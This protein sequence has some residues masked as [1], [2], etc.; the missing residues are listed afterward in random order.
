MSLPADAAEGTLR[1]LIQASPL[2]ITALDPDGVVLVWN[3]AAERVF[4]WTAD[5]IVG[6]SVPL[7][8]EGGEEEHRALRER[9]LAGEAIAGVEVRRRC[10]DGSIVDVRLSTAPL[11]DGAGNV[12]GAMAILED[13]TQQKHADE[14]LRQSE[15]RFRAIFDSARVGIVVTSPDGFVVESN[16][17]FRSMVGYSEQELAVMPF[18][19]YTHP[20][21]LVLNLG[22]FEELRAGARDSYEIVKRLIRKDGDLRW[23]RLTTSRASD[24][25]GR[26]V[27][28]AVIDDVTEKKR[29]EEALRASEERFRELFENAYDLM[30]TLDLD[31]TIV[32]LSRSV[33]RIM[34]YAPDEL[35]G[36]HF[37][38]IVT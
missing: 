11:Q 19:A 29:A 13:I 20:D 5:E 21:D 14:A 8:P 12:V 16:Q 6:R 23:I 2:P 32:S 3:S 18:S 36:Q 22:L 30:Y 1:A 33:E 15:E 37:S 9:T 27:L 10:K 35:V 28:I 31:G 24:S 7:V 34:G 38:V 25:E 26:A 4:G 17:A